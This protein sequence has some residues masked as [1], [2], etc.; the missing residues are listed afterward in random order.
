[1]RAVFTWEPLPV[2][3]KNEGK[4]GCLLLCGGKSSRMGRDKAKLIYQNQ[5]FLEIISAKLR[6]TGMP[7]YISLADHEEEIPGGFIPLYDAVHDEN[8]STIGPLGGIYT[9]L[10]QCA[11]DGLSGLFAVPVDAP[12]FETEILELIAKAHAEE[13]DA[14]LLIPVTSGG[15]EHPACGYYSLSVMDVM[16]EMISAHDYRLRT[17]MNHPLLHCVYVRTQN[18]SQDRMLSNINRPGDY[19]ALLHEQK[20][21]HIVLQGERNAGKTTLIRKLVKN[22]NLITGGYA[23]RAVFNEAKGYREIYMYPASYLINEENQDEIAVNKGVLCGTAMNGVRETYPHVFDTYGVSLLETPGNAQL[24]IMDETGFLENEAYVFQR[25]VL[26]VL[27]GKTPVIAAVKTKDKTS[28]FL[29]SIRTHENV[30]LIEVDEE[31]RDGIYEELIRLF[32]ERKG[33]A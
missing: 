3:M 21:T 19:E 29:K 30:R 24:I 25:K 14:D 2:K 32:R 27:N 23:T 7:C 6:K 11:K 33:K 22:L 4:P 9:G 5:S 31:N 26:S 17:L 13:P 12:L 15:R 20:K 8:G 10:M 1:M 28:P 18:S 16:K